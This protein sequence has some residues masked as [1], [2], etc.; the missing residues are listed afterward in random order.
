MSTDLDC[1]QEYFEERRPDGFYPRLFV[2]LKEL[3]KETFLATTTFNEDFYQQVVAWSKNQ[4]YKVPGGEEFRATLLGMIAHEKHGTAITAL[5]THSLIGQDGTV[6]PLTDT[7]RCKVRLAL[8]APTHAPKPITIMFENQI[9]TLNAIR[10]FDEAKEKVKGGM[11]PIAYE[12][13]KCSSDQPEG[14]EHNLILVNM[15][16]KYTDDQVPERAQSSSPRKTKDRQDVPDLLND[17]SDSTAERSDVEPTASTSSNQLAAADDDDAYVGKRY[18]PELQ[19]DYGGPCCQLKHNKLIQHN[20][21]DIDGNLI[22]PWKYHV[23]LRPGTI[24][25]IE[26]TIHCYNMTQGKR[27]RKYYQI[28][29]HNTQVLLPSKFPV[30]VP[31]RPEAAAAGCAGQQTLPDLLAKNPATPKSRKTVADFTRIASALSKPSII[32]GTSG[33]GSS[34]GSKM[35]GGEDVGSLGFKGKGKATIRIPVGDSKRPRKKARVEVSEDGMD[36]V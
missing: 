36:V 8:C 18:P 10:D 19:V 20:V 33:Q 27:D 29:A 12:A 25:L 35:E 32:A 1:L 3:P 17:A 2:Q 21:R 16:V 4:V 28:N 11:R 5:G 15:G 9:A 22:P 26:A 13:T 6:V 23:D 34:V 31:V 14:S 30:E 7:S 24:V